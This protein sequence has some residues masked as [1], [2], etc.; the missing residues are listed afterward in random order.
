MHTK[1]PFTKRKRRI[2]YCSLIDIWMKSNISLIHWVNI[3]PV[4]FNILA[5]RFNVLTFRYIGFF[6]YSHDS[7]D[8]Q[9]AKQNATEQIM[10]PDNNIASSFLF[11]IYMYKV[12]GINSYAICD[13]L[14]CI[15]Q[16]HVNTKY[17][18]ILYLGPFK[19]I[20]PYNLLT[21]LWDLCDFSSS[22]RNH[23]TAKTVK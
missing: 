3:W 1:A 13:Y 20:A 4:R 16:K 8:E 9:L 18:V 22:E 21:I 15:V 6:L 11:Y 2:Q 7:F 23:F 17:S 14:K 19:M 5:I 12:S 10:S